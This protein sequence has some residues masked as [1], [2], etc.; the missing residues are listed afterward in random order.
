MSD[1]CWD[2]T[3]SLFVSTHSSCSNAHFLN[4]SFCASGMNGVMRRYQG[5]LF[6][7]FHFFFGKFT[8]KNRLVKVE[9]SS[10]TRAFEVH[11]IPILIFSTYCQYFIHCEWSIF[12]VRTGQKS[13]KKVFGVCIISI[14]TNLLFNYVL[15]FLR[16][17]VKEFNRSLHVLRAI[18][19]TKLFFTL[20]SK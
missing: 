9:Q 3:V 1:S 7:A 4:R 16:L 6:K 19:Y 14:A 17:Y 8:R 13:K 20:M 15:N 11:S 12:S 5:N 18:S 2:V 10:K